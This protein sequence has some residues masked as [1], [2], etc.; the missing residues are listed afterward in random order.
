MRLVAAVAELGSL[1]RSMRT[2]VFI[3]CSLAVLCGCASKP[4]PHVQMELPLV[5]GDC[6]IVTSAH[7]DRLESGQVIDSAGDISLPLL[8]RHH[9]AGFTV[10]QAEE[11][12]EREYV[13]RGFFRQMLDMVVIRCP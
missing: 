4:K 5:A 8:G 9:I 7:R 1:G 6:V 10:K 12:I 13:E 3:A 11:R 2:P